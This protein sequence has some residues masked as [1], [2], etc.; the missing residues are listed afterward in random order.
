MRLIV[1]N[2]GFA[3][4]RVPARN[5]HVHYTSRSY[6]IG[7][8]NALIVAFYNCRTGFMTNPDANAAL[9]RQFYDEMF[10][11]GTSSSPNASTVP[12]TATT[13][14]PYPAPPLITLPT[15][16]ATPASR[17]P[18]RTAASAWDTPRASDAP[19]QPAGAQRVRFFSRMAASRR[20]TA[21]RSWMRAAVRAAG[22]VP[23]SPALRR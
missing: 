10:N 17:P 2:T 8:E 21:D 22:D 9:I 4:S 11:R 16:P 18:S 7:G 13:I 5:T 3:Q 14:S 1:G 19:D 6:G 23:S 20:L 12:A 15:W